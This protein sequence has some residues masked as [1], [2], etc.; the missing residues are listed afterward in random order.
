MSKD[1]LPLE[2]DVDIELEYKVYHLWDKVKK[3]LKFIVATVL[4]L[5]IFS[6]GYYF[7]K[8]KKEEENQKA[9]VY[10][11]KINN[12]L[13]DNKKDE[14]QKLIQEFEKNY[15]DT[16]YYKVILAYKIMM[17]KEENK[18]DISLAKELKNKLQTELSKGMIEYESYLEY[19]SGKQNEAKE[20]L[21]S[22]NKEDY[23]YISAQSLLALIYK[24]EGNFQEAE[25][26]FK[27]IQENK[28]Y[29]YFSILARENL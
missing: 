18:E 22:I 20:M 7:Y 4:I 5:F 1:K 16:D 21:K 24:K 26:I 27:T 12:L 15:K 6:L 9:S 11:T 10:I 14:A 19:K 23:N 8:Q 2:K 17:M 3:Y 29:R 28:N 13:A 25:K